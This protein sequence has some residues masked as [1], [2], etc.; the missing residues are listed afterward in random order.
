[1]TS[2]T[3]VVAFPVEAGLSFIIIVV[4][5]FVFFQR[6]DA[7]RPYLP[8]LLHSPL[9]NLLLLFYF[10]FSPTF[11]AR[12]LS[13]GSYFSFVFLPFSS[14]FQN[15]CISF[16]GYFKCIVSMFTLQDT[17][18]CL[19]YSGKTSK[20]RALSSYSFLSYFALIFLNLRFKL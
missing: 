9:N 2:F 7:L 3:I 20:T 12:T 1:M 6:S 16:Y 19:Y 17:L 15:Q 4:C 13:S 8:H 5:V 11:T 10:F 14:V 18:T